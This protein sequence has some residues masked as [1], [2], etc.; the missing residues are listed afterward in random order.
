MANEQDIEL[1]TQRLEAFSD[2]VF[3]I[4]ITLLI[5]EIRVPHVEGVSEGKR[6]ANALFDLWTS[7]FAYILSF[8]MIGIYW[9]NHH[10]L[11]KFFKKTDHI[12]NLLNVFFLMCISFLPFPTAVL[13][14]YMNNPHE[15]HTAVSLYA[16]GLLLPAFA[17]LLVWFYGSSKQRLLDHKL[18]PAFVKA[19][20]RQYLLSNLLYLCAVVVSFWHTT[21]SLV[22]CVCLTLL[23]LLPPKK[24]VYR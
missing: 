21:T 13:A 19:L 2:G 12:F 20:K 23:Y 9:A 24:P 11:F 4:A 22:I 3:A 18:A 10:Y 1:T 15:R 14:E 7:Y 6:L 17:F 5:L 16:F 8:V